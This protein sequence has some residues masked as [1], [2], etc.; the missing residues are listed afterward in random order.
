MRG[1]PVQ[2]YRVQRKEKTERTKRKSGS[3]DLIKDFEAID[4][5]DT[6]DSDEEEEEIPAGQLEMNAEDLAEVNN[7]FLDIMANYLE[8]L[9]YS[10]GLIANREFDAEVIA[11]LTGSIRPLINSSISMGH[12]QMAEILE[13]I[14]QPIQEFSAENKDSFS[15][16]DILWIKNSYNELVNFFPASMNVPQFPDGVADTGKSDVISIIRGI[17][18]VG[19]NEVERLFS[20]GL[21]SVEMLKSAPAME[22]AAV[23]GLDIDIAKRIVNAITRGGAEEVIDVAEPVIQVEMDTLLIEILD[24]T[25]EVVNR[26]HRSINKRKVN[27]EKL[28]HERGQKEIYY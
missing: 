22:I 27:V 9:V 6:S 15:E 24:D 5:F 10:L 13:R 3:R 17:E 11:S 21:T 28:L 12:T 8:P 1:T 7:I 2:E 20:T 23:T 4:L 16:A 26:F 14:E 18:G 19:V 25:R